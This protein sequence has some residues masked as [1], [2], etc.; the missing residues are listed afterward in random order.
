DLADDEGSDEDAIVALDA[1]RVG[2]VL[3]GE[4]GGRAEELVASRGGALVL[5]QLGPGPAHCR[6]SAAA[7]R[8]S[9]GRTPQT[10]QSSGGPSRR[11]RWERI[12]PSC[13]QPRPATVFFATSLRAGIRP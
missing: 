12:V 3:G 10:S 1:E 4:E 5:D 8:N 9:S 11:A 2:D 7:T 13:F 6:R